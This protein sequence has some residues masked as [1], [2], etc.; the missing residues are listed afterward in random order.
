MILLAQHARLD[1]RRAS[2]ERNVTQDKFFRDHLTDAS[3]AQQTSTTKRPVERSIGRSLVAPR[4]L[5][6]GARSRRRASVR[7]LTRDDA[8]RLAR[9][10]RERRRRARRSRRRRRRRRAVAAGFT[11]HPSDV[12]RGRGVRRPRPSRAP[13]RA[14]DDVERA[15]DV[16]YHQARA[17]DDGHRARGRLPARGR[18]RRRGRVGS[19]RP[20]PSG[21]GRAAAARTVGHPARG[22]QPNARGDARVRARRPRRDAPRRG[23]SARED[24]RRA[25][26]PAR[27][28]PVRVPTRGGGRGRREEDAPR[29]LTRDDAAD[30]RRVRAA[31]VAVPGDPERDDRDAAGD[32]H[33]GQRGVRDHDDRPNRRRRRRVR[34]RRRRRDAI[35]RR[36]PRRP[37]RER[38]GDRDRVRVERRRGRGGGGGRGERRRGAQRAVPRDGRGDVRDD[39]RG[40]RVWCVRVLFFQ[41]ERV[42]PVVPRFQHQ[43]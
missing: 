23:A 12:S 27:D 21:N 8:R 16:V 22:P 39:A 2:T 18:R 17:D 32:D 7:L 28:D 24:A 31:R 43:I 25:R 20:P 14:G 36:A 4:A 26:A 33:G 15:R 9:G 38:A 41:T 11:E 34:R 10:C 40:D 19:G 6:D 5:R 3:G 29:R 37:P 42:S 13:S 35:R 30:E 1:A